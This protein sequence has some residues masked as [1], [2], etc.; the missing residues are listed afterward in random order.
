MQQQRQPKQIDCIFYLNLDHRP[1]RRA[2]IESELQPVAELLGYPMERFPAIFHFSIGAVG[3]MKSHLAV[4]KEAKKRN[5]R[6]ILIVE[7]DFQ[8]NFP[9]AEICERFK[10]IEISSTQECPSK[11][12]YVY[13]R[14]DQHDCFLWLGYNVYLLENLDEEI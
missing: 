2:K 6:R 4:L 14:L 8:W 13:D 5:Y 9:A 11:K 3:C 7:D 10:E 12:W 1:D